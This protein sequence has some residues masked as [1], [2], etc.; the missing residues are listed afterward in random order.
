MNKLETIIE[1]HSVG[2]VLPFSKV[3]GEKMWPL[4][5][6]DLNL[7]AFCVWPL[8]ETEASCA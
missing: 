7:M 4:S 5:F 3:L 8:L 2:D 1:L 6:T